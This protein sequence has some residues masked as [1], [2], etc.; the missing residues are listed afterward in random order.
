MFVPISIEDYIRF[1]LK[2]NPDENE[3]QLRKKL[4][5]ALKAHQEGKKCSCGNDLWV[6]GSAAV[7]L[8]CFTCITGE[9]FPDGE[10]EIDQAIKTVR[11]KDGRRHIDDIPPDRIAGIFDDD[12]YEILPDSIKKPGLCLTCIYEDDSYEYILCLLNRNDQKD[13]ADFKCHKYKRKQI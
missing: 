12:G 1:H 9:S 4:N 2:S 7:G 13:E 6:I 5:E 10:F 11:R 8:S 3:D